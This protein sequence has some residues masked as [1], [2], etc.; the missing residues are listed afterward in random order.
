M[1]C[2]FK[3]AFLI[4]LTLL[5]IDNLFNKIKVGNKTKKPTP[6]AIG[7]SGRPLDNKYMKP[8]KLKTTSTITT[9][10]SIIIIKQAIASEDTL[11]FIFG[12]FLL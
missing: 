8:F 9:I 10:N 5:S 3:S 7:P 6:I 1:P 11:A 12:H 2:T 4:V